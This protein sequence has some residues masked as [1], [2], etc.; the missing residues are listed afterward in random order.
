MGPAVSYVDLPENVN[1]IVLINGET[2]DK[3]TIQIDNQQVLLSVIENNFTN[4]LF[5][6]TFR[7]PENTFAYI[8]GTNTNNTIV[9]G[10]F[11]F[12]S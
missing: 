9:W 4:S 6:E 5:D 3:Y 7:Y 10:F 2:I 1:K 12:A 8:C 11:K